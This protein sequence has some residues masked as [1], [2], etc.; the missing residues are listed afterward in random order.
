M[1]RAWLIARIAVSVL[2]LATVVWRTDLRDAASVIGDAHPA[3]LALALLINVAA[4]AGSTALWRTMLAGRPPAS[5]GSMLRAYF[6]GLFYNNIGF[7]TALGDISRGAALAASGARAGHAAV[8]VMSERIVSCLALLALASAGAF[9]L[10][11]RHASAAIGVWALFFTTLAGI[12]AFAAILPRAPALRAMSPTR[13]ALADASA[14]SLELVRDSVHL[15]RAAGIAIGVQLC[16]VAASV[17]VLRSLGEVISLPQALA[18]VPMIAVFVLLPIS[19]QGIGVREATYVYGCS[20]IGI[21]DE[22]ALSAALLSY[23]TTVAVSLVGAALLVSALARRHA[24]EPAPARSTAQGE[25]GLAL[26]NR[27]RVSGR[28]S[29]AHRF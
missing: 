15:A 17:C 4:V 21:A 18:V 6:V 3:W 27:R 20:L 12:A 7:G 1:K 25:G 26:R 28:I 23:L 16:T 24:I 10:L 14:A 19:V 11:P 29:R 8:S 2:A 9:Y 13:H 5:F 22:I